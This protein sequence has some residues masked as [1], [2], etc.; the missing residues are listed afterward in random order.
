[1]STMNSKTGK[2][3]TQYSVEELKEAS[4]LMRGY[5]LIALAAAGSGH[6]GGSL[7][8]M[9][10]AAALYLNELR[11]DHDTHPGQTVTGY[12]GQQVTRRPR[13]T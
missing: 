8:I 3:R 6:P 9:D 5:A 10:I 1:M 4:Q 7:S 11:H 2:L 12:S 13:S